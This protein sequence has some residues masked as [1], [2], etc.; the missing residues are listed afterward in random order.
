V[1]PVPAQTWQR[2]AR[3]RRRC[4][5]SVPAIGHAS[6]TGVLE[7]PARE[8]HVHARRNLRRAESITR[9]SARATP[10]STHPS[11][12]HARTHAHT[13][14]RPCIHPRTATRISTHTQTHM[15]T[16]GAITGLTHANPH[17]YAHTHQTHPQTPARTH[18]TTRSHTHAHAHARA[19]THC[20]LAWGT[21]RLSSLYRIS[22][23]LEIRLPRPHV[24][25]CT[26]AQLPSGVRKELGA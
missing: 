5:E 24:V 19:C 11:R 18:G 17:A 3:S 2:W 25:V 7:H 12:T 14:A 22:L 6:P 4:G 26:P 13:R 20:A 23:G 8:E 1:G 16:T 9:A 10:V 21:R 15:C